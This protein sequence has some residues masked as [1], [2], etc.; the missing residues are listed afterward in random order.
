V[1]RISGVTFVDTL[2]ELMGYRLGA[3]IQE[4]LGSIFLPFLI[5]IGALCCVYYHCLEKQTF[6]PLVFYFCYLLFI[7]WLVSPV[8]TQVGF[9]AGTAPESI[10]EFKTLYES[11][12][13]AGTTVKIPRVLLAVHSLTDNAVKVMVH[14]TNRTF[15][16]NPFGSERL[17]ARLRQSGINDAVL[18]ERFLRFVAG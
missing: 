4:F 5:S 18:R 11:K 15:L 6:R 13:G 7:W 16:D 10:E 14:R 12:D 2:Y 17:A 9:P 1:N 8:A 3:S